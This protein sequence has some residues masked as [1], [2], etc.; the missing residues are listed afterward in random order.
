MAAEI[1]I[2][3]CPLDCF[4]L[5]NLDPYSSL[6]N[7]LGTFSSTIP[8]PLSSIAIL[9]S[10]FARVLISIFKSGKIPACSHAS[11]LLSTPS[12]TAVIREWVGLSNP[13]I[14]RF[15]SKNSETGMSRCSLA[16]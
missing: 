8:G 16:S 15:C 4:P 6:P 2:P 3:C 14:C 1:P 7:T 9:S 5:P 10:S 13:K 11:R 12:L